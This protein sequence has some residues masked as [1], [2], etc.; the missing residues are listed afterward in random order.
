MVVGLSLGGT[1][2]AYV[3]A[4]FRSDLGGGEP[5]AA[6][7]CAGRLSKQS[8]YHSPPLDC[9]YEYVRDNVPQGLAAVMLA[10]SELEY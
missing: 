3:N 7:G 4:D 2:N 8:P 1:Y 6:P 5:P 10:S 9:R